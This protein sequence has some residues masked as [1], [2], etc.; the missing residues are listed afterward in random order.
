MIFADGTTANNKY[1]LPLKKG[2]FAG[3]RTV[4]PVALHFDYEDI[5]PSIDVNYSLPLI[6][7]SFAIPKLG[8]VTIFELPMFKPND[9]LFETHKDKG[10]EKWE[11]FS[12]AVRDAIS[13]VTGKP[14][15]DSQARE[16]LEFEA[17]IRA[18]GKTPRPKQE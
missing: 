17:I 15:I 14:K 16:K 2:V 13:K 1:V 8:E 12:W 4:T 18:K 6:F 7:L 3:L 10:T 9:Y 5:S 11:I